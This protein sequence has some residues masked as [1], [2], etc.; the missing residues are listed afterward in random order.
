MIDSSSRGDNEDESRRPAELLCDRNT[1]KMGP[2][3]CRHESLYGSVTRA[4]ASRLYD[5]PQRL[6]TCA[7]L[8]TKCEFERTLC[9]RRLRHL[10]ASI[11]QEDAEN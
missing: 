9:V 2:T 3:R 4:R 1:S 10:Y 8:V 7:D 11:A 6:P 5:Q